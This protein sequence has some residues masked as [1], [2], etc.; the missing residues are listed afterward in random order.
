MLVEER[1]RKWLLPAYESRVR[2]LSVALLSV[3]VLAVFGGALTLHRLN[4]QYS[5]RQFMP[6]DHPLYRSDREIKRVFR[7]TEEEPIIVN[8]KLDAATPGT[9]LEP[10]RVALLE[11]ATA[12]VARLEGIQ[13]V[14]SIANVQM[15]GD[16]GRGIE[17]DNVLKLTS[18]SAWKER[19]LKDPLLA[20]GLISADGRVVTLMGQINMMPEGQL[21]AIVAQIRSEV[22]AIAAEGGAHTSVSGVAP[23][24]NDMASLVSKELRNFFL[25]AFLACFITLVAYFRSFS[26]VV[27]CLILVVIANIATLTWLALAGIPFSILSST[28]PIMCSIEALAIGSHTLL[29]FSDNYRQALAL[30]PLATK[31]EVIWKSYRALLFPNYLMSGT[32]IIG[33]ATLITSSVPLIRQFSQSVCGGIMLSCI[34]M[35]IALPPLM[36]LFPV[37]VARRFTASKARWT[38]WVIQHRRLVLSAAAAVVVVFLVHGLRLNWAVRLYD[39]LPKAGDIKTSADLIDQNMGGMIP[40]N[41]LVKVPG[42]SDPWHEPSRIERAAEVLRRWR[43]EPTVGS[44]I[45]LPDLLKTGIQKI[46]SRKAIAEVLFLYAFNGADNPTNAFLSTDGSSTRLLF[47]LKDIPADRMKDLVGRIEADVREAFPE[48]QVQVGGM[49]VMAHPLNAELSSDLI[50]GLWQSLVLISVL[51]IVVFRSVRL[52]LVAAVPNLLPPLVLLATMAYLKTPVKP[53]VAI[54]F[55][56]ALGLAY[57][58][59]VFLMTRLRKLQA[60][61][62]QSADVIHRTW[63]QEGNPCLFSSLA[64]IGGFAV[65]LA[66]YFSPNRIFGAYM[67]WSIGVGII[68]DLVVLPALVAAFPWL[69]FPEEPVGGR[70][71]LAGAGHFRKNFLVFGLL[72]LGLTGPSAAAAESVVHTPFLM[73]LDQQSFE[74]IFFNAVIT[75]SLTGSTASDLPNISETS[76]FKFSVTGLHL[77]VK[78]AF[79]SP[80]NR[81][82]GWSVQ[83]KALSAELVVDRVDANQVIEV[84]QDG[85][86]VDVN[87]PAVCSNVHLTLP[88]GAST[89]NGLLDLTTDQSGKPRLVLQNFQ[90]NWTAGAWKVVSMSCSGAYGF[91]KVVANRAQDRLSSINP[92]LNTIQSAIQASLDKGMSAPIDVEMAN[93]LDASHKVRLTAAPGKGNRAGG[94]VQMQGDAYFSFGKAQAKCGADIHSFKQ[95]PRLDAAGNSIVFPFAALTALLACA[96]A[97]GSLALDS[98]SQHFQPF[99]DLQQDYFAKAAVWPELNRYDNNANFH[100]HG[101]TSDAPAISNE[102]PAGTHEF[103]AQLKQPFMVGIKAPASGNAYVN[104]VQVQGLYEGPVSVTA[105]DGKM[106]VSASPRAAVTLNGAYYASYVKNYQPQD[107]RIDWATLTQRAQASIGQL[108]QTIKLPQY[109]V[110]PTLLIKAMEGDLEGTNV[111]IGLDVVHGAK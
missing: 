97:D 47:R 11:R 22:G 28:L 29:I 100:F 83:S 98:D 92:Y 12:A 31:A 27:V 74:S 35:S 80:Q 108:S 26:T 10:A 59:T 51:L 103:T 17:V 40:L 110:N 24:Q 37:P 69:L 81:G 66:S 5:M 105:A 90:A 58:N 106:V 46:D 75:N 63:Y 43:A 88:E 91:D 56:I 32:T 73:Q 9:W 20:P 78:Y 77:S 89:A 57:N 86:I 84:V 2:A 8:L 34:S 85:T 76:P 23:L 87:V 33:F 30:N 111:R 18:P 109:A 50:F 68:G 14:T 99:H 71:A 25:L 36:V 1:M 42:E 3:I 72:F 49:A 4:S 15:A 54:I 13:S 38:L 62:A 95:A 101:Y 16:N 39:D 79:N 55:S 19:V 52:A 45:G 64:V 93:P 53:V 70:L 44:A 21:H 94:G 65:F 102:Q 107:T 104:F 61:F 60:R 67:L 82:D 6:A 41:V 96:H 48:A 7:L